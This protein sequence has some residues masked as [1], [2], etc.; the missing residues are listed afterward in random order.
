MPD[1]W[2]VPGSLILAHVRERPIRN[3]LSIVG[4]ALGVLAS[5]SIGTANVHVLQSFDRAVRAV[6]GSATLEIIGHDLGVDEAVIR[7]VR[8]LPGVETAAP[9]LEQGVVMQTGEHQGE[10]LQVFGIDLLAEL[11][12]ANGRFLVTHEDRERTLEDVVSAE[13]VYL[14]RSLADSW[15]LHPGGFL[16]VQGGGRNLRLRVAGVIQGAEGTGSL[17]DRAAAMDIAAAQVN[18]AAIGRLDRIDIVTEAGWNV[19]DVAASIRGVLPP[20]L[21]VQRPAQRSKQ[22]ENMVRSFQL[23]LTVLSW[24]GLLVGTFLIY[25]TMAFAVTQRR[26]EIGIYRALGMAERRIAALFLL[27]GGLLGFIGGMLG[28]I[29]GVWVSRALMTLVS[30]T[31]SDLYVPIG[32]GDPTTWLDA[33]T[34]MAVLKGTA[35]GTMVAMAGALAPSLEASR[36]VTV[37]A[38]APGDYEETQRVRSRRYL[39]VSVLLLVCA[40]V[41]SLPGPIN[42]LPLFGYLATLCLLGSLVALSPVCIQALGRHEVSRSNASLAL[43]GGLRRMAAEHAARHPGRNAVTVSALMVGLAIMIGVVV[44]VRSFRETVETWVNETVMADLIVAPFGWLQGQQVGHA[45]RALPDSLAAVLSSFEGV[46]AVDTYRNVQVEVEGRSAMLVSRDMR[47][48]AQRSRYLLVRGD[49]A[50]AL[51]RAAESGGVLIS[52]V[53]ADRLGVREGGRVTIRTP[54][55]PRSVP[56]EGIFYD[57]ATDGGKMV[58]D[59]APYQ[60]L[61]ND[62]SVTV[63]AVYLGTGVDSETVRAAMVRAFAGRQDGV[64]P[65]MVIKNKELRREILD[66]FDRTFILTYVLELIAVL[67]AVLG[68]VNTLVTAILERRRELATLQAIGASRKQVERLVLWEAVYLGSI[69]AV[70]GVIGGLGLAWILITV[71]N[72]QSFGWTIR[73]T[74]PIEVLVQAVTIGVAA[75]WIA[76]Y[77]PARWAARQSAVEGLRQ[78]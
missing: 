25:N 14:G 49:S 6:S 73:M 20:H 67:V 53:L 65:P 72:K 9:F 64:L 12:S 36:T 56:I 31:I 60:Q 50:A 66:I 15:H 45:A 4:V 3:V 75:A 27:E 69:G 40:G 30:R 61:W 57:Y 22:V 33:Q 74:V 71:I 35:F 54:Q 39:V 10:V 23:N 52:E 47:M 34:V 78:E 29:A 63:F 76:G 26:R 16:D 32:A 8:N 42:G 38:L 43:E 17:W 46:A 48:H 24:V 13:A 41:L 55:G 77:L 51:T 37:R 7:S 21:V 11:G 44:M 58:M 68:I 1:L 18:F 70:L 59:R 5:V 28:G 2:S 19:D 62:H